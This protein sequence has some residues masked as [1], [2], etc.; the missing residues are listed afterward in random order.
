MYKEKHH[1]SVQRKMH[2]VKTTKTQ[3]LKNKNRKKNYHTNY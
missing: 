1:D 3:I 2:I